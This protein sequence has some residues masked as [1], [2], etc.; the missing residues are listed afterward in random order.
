MSHYPYWPNPFRRHDENTRKTWGTIFQWT[1]DHMTLEQMIPLRYSYDILGEE[2]LNRLDAISPPPQPS[3]LRHKTETVGNE[4]VKVDTPKRDLYV[5]LRDNASEDPKLR[6]LWDEVNTIPE[7]VDWDQIARGQD[8]FYRYGGVALTAVSI[9]TANI[10]NAA[11]F[12]SS[13]GRCFS[14]TSLT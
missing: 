9:Y 7:W 3:P 8:V 1:P 11:S 13:I 2:C 4:P 10:P 14:T 12:Q 5:L 6:E